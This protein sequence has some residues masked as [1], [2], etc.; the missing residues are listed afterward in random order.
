MADVADALTELAVVPSFS[1]LGPAI[2]NRLYHWEDMP[3]RSLEG[4]TAVITGPTSGIGR[5]A[6]EMLAAAGARL[7]LVGRSPDKLETLVDKLAL[8]AGRDRFVP[9]VAD[10]SS[11]SSVRDAAGSIAAHAPRID[12]LVDNAGAIYPARE[13]SVDGIEKTLAIL[14][15][16]P[17]ALVSELRPQLEAA[18]DARVIAVTSGGMYTQPVRL[19]DLQWRH[20][21]YNGTR[22]YAQAKRIQV[23][24]IREWARRYPASGV[25]FNAMHPGWAATPGLAESLPGFSRLMRPLLRTPAQGADTIAWLA[26]T[27]SLPAPGGNLYLDRRPRPFDR[28]PQTRLSAEDRAELWEMVSQL[29]AE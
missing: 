8:A 22:A 15:C 14:V 24:L 18:T 5:A 2:R 13:E 27:P 26:R 12:L 11:L 16:G 3:L 25:S 23:A 21:P 28:V 4:R 1:N 17:F 9:V 7:V 20:R 6:T 19:D 10:M 29:T